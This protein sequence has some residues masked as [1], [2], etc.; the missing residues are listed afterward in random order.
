MVRISRA[1]KRRPHVVILSEERKNLLAPCHSERSEES[2]KIA[3]GALHPRNDRFDALP[4]DR[5][6]QFVGTTVR[7]GPYRDRYVGG[8]SEDDGPYIIGAVT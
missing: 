7:G 4:Q 8:P 2:S 1:A 5:A 6:I 3:T